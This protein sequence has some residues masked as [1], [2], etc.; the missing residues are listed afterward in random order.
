MSRARPPASFVDDG[1]LG[2][3]KGPRFDDLVRRSASRD[4]NACA[5]ICGEARLSYRNLVNATEAVSM[6]IRELAIP[7][8]SLVAV[9]MERDLGLPAAILGVME[10][11]CGCVPMDPRHPDPHLMDMI[12]DSGSRACIVDKKSSHRL[13]ESGAVLLEI[14]EALAA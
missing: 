11:G 13:L 1:A 12:T 10:A 3:P 2:K 8:G 14:T 4:P 7:P 9:C 5:V 6:S